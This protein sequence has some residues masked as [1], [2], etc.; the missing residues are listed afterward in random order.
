MEYI[1]GGN[2]GQC[3]KNTGTL[4]ETEAL[5]IIEAVAGA[6][7]AAQEKNIIHRDIK[8]DNIMFTSRGEVKLAD[9]GV[10]KSTSDNTGMTM[11]NT[12]LGTPAYISPEQARDAKYVDIRADIYSLGATLFEMLTGHPPYK[13]NNTY[14]TLAKLMDDPVPNPKF[15]NET[16]SNATMR[17]TMRMLA[18]NP[19]QRYQTPT[20]LL[21]AIHKILPP[22]SQIDNQETIRSLLKRS[23]SGDRTSGT[24]TPS[25]R[26]WKIRSTISTFIARRK[27]SFPMLWLTLVILLGSIPIA[28]W[29][30]VDKSSP[31]MPPVSPVSQAPASVVDKS[32]PLKPPVS[33]VSQAPASVV[34]KSS[35]PKPPVS[36]VSQAPASKAVPSP[37][38]K[39]AANDSL[40]PKP[41]EIVKRP[42]PSPKK[43]IPPKD[44]TVLLYTT[45]DPRLVKYI[46]QVGGEYRVGQGKWQKV[47]RFPWPVSLAPGKYKISIK[48]KGTNPVS[49]NEIQVDSAKNISSHFIVEAI[50]ATLKIVSDLPKSRFFYEKRWYDC[51]GKI[52]VP[53][54]QA[55]ELKVS[56]NNMPD[57][58]IKV[59]ALKPGETF[60]KKLEL[61][62]RP[63]SKEYQDAMKLFS[64]EQYKKSLPLFEAAAKLGNDQAMYRLG[65]IYEEGLLGF[66][67]SDKDKA[68]KYYKEAAAANNRQALYKVAVFTEN[69]RG[70]ASG[71]ASEAVKYYLEAAKLGQRD[72][73][74]RCG[75]IYSSGWGNVEVNDQEAMQYFKTAAEAGHVEAQ[76]Q[77][78]QYYEE[79]K[80]VPANTPDAVKWYKKAADNGH[81]KA[82]R[83]YEAMTAK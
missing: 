36:P 47:K 55:L 10:A 73:L 39:P 19:L 59:A 77:V 26:Y 64:S 17:L 60:I 4:T 33:P 35:P 46:N 32:S 41:E 58:K 23:L 56:T 6:L 62:K 42:P 83:K 30:F 61:S 52:E 20:E 79:G 3:L 57:T 25:T 74:F 72:A 27:K 1:D 13:G 81:H 11:T 51:P 49:A 43:I 14:D 37:T 68:F 50:P 71:K 7:Q 8:P 78:A 44:G 70:G 34:D 38:L 69:G 40:S 75:E 66:W 16:I 18:K 22:R 63:G 53:P 67:S 48:I 45:A 15:L 12:L 54:F 24:D 9:L 76:Y 28:R 80:G 2:V 82:R 5:V 29:L 65:F 31:P 21:Q